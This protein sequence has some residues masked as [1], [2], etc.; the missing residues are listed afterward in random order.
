[1]KKIVL[2]AEAHRTPLFTGVQLTEGHVFWLKENGISLPITN[3][4]REV[5][6]YTAWANTNRDNPILVE[7]L[8]LYKDTVTAINNEVKR[9][10][11][12]VKTANKEFSFWTR[13]VASNIIK[14]KGKGHLSVDIVRACMKNGKTFDEILESFKEDYRHKSK[15]HPIAEFE[16][17]KEWM[18][19]AKTAA[20]ELEEFLNTNGMVETVVLAALVDSFKVVEYDDTKF[21]PKIVIESSSYAN[22]DEIYDVYRETLH[23]IPIATSNITEECLASFVSEQDVAGLLQYLR[24]RNVTIV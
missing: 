20:S 21:T 23:L 15:T 6:V 18:G 24:E 1:M 7:C 22:F 13:V 17:A 14:R 11:N 10:D 5:S 2:N 8:E 3:N 19:K 9:L 4:E 16:K 12:E